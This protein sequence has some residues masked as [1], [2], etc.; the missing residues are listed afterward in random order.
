VSN[1][2]P[3]GLDLDRIAPHLADATGGVLTGPLTGEVISGGRSNLTY[4]VGNGAHRF[5]VRRPPLGLVLPSA[6]DMSR[7]YR[8]TA[9]LFEAGFPVARPLLLC[10]DPEVIGAPFYVMEYVDGVVLRDPSRRPSLK[11]AARC[12]ELLVDLLVKL[13]SINPDAVGLAD[14]GRPDGYLLRQVRRWHKQWEASKTRELPLLDSVTAALMADLPESARAG[15]VHGDYRLDNVM[16]TPDLTRIAAV[17]DWEMATIGDPLADVGLLV[18]YT[19]LAQLD[20]ITPVPPGFPGGEQLAARYAEATGV[21]VDRLDWYVAFGSY[22]LAVISEGIHARY[23]QGKTVGGGFERFGPAVETL[24]ER[25]AAT[26]GK[27]D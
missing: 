2:S 4:L 23:L 13:H 7:E 9:A 17:M 26:L 14:F 22:K 19:D 16:F 27:E 18:V 11:A 15:I 20:M 10:T 24:I 8:V 3:P 6:H 5:V 12:A 1:P 25:A 21:A